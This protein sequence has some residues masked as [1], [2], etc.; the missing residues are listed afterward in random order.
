MASEKLCNDVS[1]RCRV[2]ARWCGKNSC[3]VSIGSRWIDDSYLA[4]RAESRID[5]QDAF[6]LERRL[7]Q[8]AS[9][10]FGKDADRV[11]FCLVCD[12]PADFAFDTRVDQP[13]ERI[14]DALTQEVAVNVTA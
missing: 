1:G 12:F 10:V 8:Q 4:A 2:V 9:E 14:L 3:V 6:V 5:C 11:F 13:V 7:K